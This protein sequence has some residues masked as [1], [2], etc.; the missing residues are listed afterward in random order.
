MFGVKDFAMLICELHCTTRRPHL[1]PCSAS[2][3][4]SQSFG[5]MPLPTR[6]A[7]CA[8]WPTSPRGGEA[9][10]GEARLRAPAAVLFEVPR[11]L[12]RLVAQHQ[13]PSMLLR[14]VE[15]PRFLLEHPKRLEVG[16]HRPRHAQV[17]RLADEVARHRACQLA[18]A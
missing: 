13:E 5:W 18:R 17:R 2:T 3:P 6:R 9:R 14:L 15:Q 4:F 8:S 7:R 10:S 11:G 1:P 16:R 12:V